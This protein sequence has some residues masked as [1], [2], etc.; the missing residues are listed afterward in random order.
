MSPL[1]FEF[2]NSIL[3]LKKPAGV[4]SFDCVRTARHILKI[5]KIGHAGTL[6]PAA[7]GLLILGI[8]TATRVLEFFEKQK[9]VYRAKFIFGKK[10]ETHDFDSTEV[11]D[12]F[13]PKI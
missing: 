5:K 3:L 8:G 4:S 10:S 9:K 2:V 11:F 7:T 6:D 1:F 13:C 12:V